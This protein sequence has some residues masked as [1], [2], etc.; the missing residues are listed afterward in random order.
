M[1]SERLVVSLR[2][3]QVVVLPSLCLVRCRCSRFLDQRTPDNKDNGSS[4]AKFILQ[5]AA[6]RKLVQSICQM[7]ST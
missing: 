3:F 6:L 7:L 5:R 2:D 1:L 4:S